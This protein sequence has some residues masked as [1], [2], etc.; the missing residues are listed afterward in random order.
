VWRCIYKRLCFHILLTYWPDNLLTYCSTVRDEH[1]RSV[2]SWVNLVDLKFR[3][4]HSFVC[5]WWSTPLPSSQCV[6]VPC[7]D[8]SPVIWRE[9][10]TSPSFH[11]PVESHWPTGHFLW[12]R[13]ERGTHCHQRSER[14][15]RIWRFDDIWIR[16][17]CLTRPS[18]AVISNIRATF[19][20]NVTARI[21]L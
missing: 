19:T 15:R 5:V 1:R 9:L 20:Q 3:S 11:Q 10:T 8:V 4:G 13:R 6:S 21:V 18:T 12:P 17:F 16:R 2:H 14:H 7:R